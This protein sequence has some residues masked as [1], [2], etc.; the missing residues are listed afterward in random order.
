ML[1]DK[2]MPNQPFDLPKAE[3]T[4]PNATRDRLMSAPSANK[5]LAVVNPAF[6]L[7]IIN[8]WLICAKNTRTFNSHWIGKN[9]AHAV[10]Q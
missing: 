7:Q 1:Q 5:F 10:P 3:I 4:F 6:S 2:K 8:T 9:E